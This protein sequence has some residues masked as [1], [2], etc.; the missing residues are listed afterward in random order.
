[1]NTCPFKLW[2]AV[3][4]ST[5]A[6]MPWC[7]HGYMYACMRVHALSLT[8][9]ILVWSGCDQSCVATKLHTKMSSTIERAKSVRTINLMS[10]LNISKPNTCCQRLL[11]RV[12]LVIPSDLSYPDLWWCSG[13][14]NTM[15]LPH[16]LYRI[17]VVSAYHYINGWHWCGGSMYKCRA[18]VTGPVWPYKRTPITEPY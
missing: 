2:W 3:C 15:L 10:I 8:H 4:T 13:T 16:I 11:P 5:S 9:T 7:M 1:M 6:L 18:E 12:Y 17:W 14:P